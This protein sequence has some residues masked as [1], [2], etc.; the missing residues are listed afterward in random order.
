MQEIF[1]KVLQMFLKSPGSAKLE[2]SIGNQSHLEVCFVFCGKT[3]IQ[4]GDLPSE[5][6]MKERR[7]G[8][9]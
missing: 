8:N 2:R 5:K 7:P 3:I 4:D 9:V 6:K 1:W